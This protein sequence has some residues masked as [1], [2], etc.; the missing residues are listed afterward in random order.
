MA[1]GSLRRHTEECRARIIK[2]M[3]GP[4]D[5]ARI[6]RSVNKSEEDIPMEEEEGEKEAEGN[7][8][9]EENV[10]ERGKRE[11]EEEEPKEEPERERKRRKLP[12]LMS[13]RRL[14]GRVSHMRSYDS[15]RRK[16]NAMLNQLEFKQPASHKI[17]TDISNII[18]ALDKHDEETPHDE[19]DESWRNL[20]NGLK[21]LDDMN[22]YKEL[23]K[24]QVIAARRLE[25]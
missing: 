10:E 9:A 1:S 5:E 15:N 20:Y 12:L 19:E 23:N 13:E 25:I 21:F 24:D 4:E 8:N 17:V 6:R 16:I 7:G 2:L 11:R 22:G 14:L 18:G 3:E